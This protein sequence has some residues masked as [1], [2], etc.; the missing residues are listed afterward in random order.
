MTSILDQFEVAAESTFKM[1][2]TSKQLL[3]ENIN[4]DEDYRGV[5]ILTKKKVNFSPNEKITQLLVSNE[6]VVLVMVN[7]VLLRINLKQDSFEEIDLLKTSSLKVKQLFLDPFGEHLLILCGNVNSSQLFYTT[8]QL[9]KLKPVG[10]YQGSEITCVAWNYYKTKTTTNT[11]GPILL[12]NS[13]G[14]IIETELGTEFDRFFQGSVVQYWKEVFDI[15]KGQPTPII[16][17]EYHR[18]GKSNL[19]YILALTLTKLYQFV[20][21]VFNKDERPMFQQVFNNYLTIPER[22]YE[23]PTVVKNTKLHFYFSNNDFTVP[24]YFGFLTEVGVLFAE[25]NINKD[26]KT[27]FDSHKLIKYSQL[28]GREDDDFTVPLSMTF[29]RY[30][31]LL[32]FT[33]R[34]IAVSLVTPADLYASQVMDED[35]FSDGHGRFLNITKDLITGTV[36]LYAERAVFRYK[37]TKE[38]RNVWKVYLDKGMFEEAKEICIDNPYRMNQVLVRQA[39]NFFNTKQYEKSA[40]IYADLNVSFEEIVLKFLHLNEKKPLKLFLMKKLESLPLED[41]TKRIMITLW[42]IELYANE[43]TEFRNYKQECSPEYKALQESF[44]HFL[45]QPSIQDCIRKNWESIYDI[46]A[47]HGDAYFMIW[48]ALENQDFKR[49]IQHYLNEENIA[50]AL[51]ILDNH[52]FSELFYIFSSDLIEKAPTQTVSIL[53]KQGQKLDPL[54]VINSLIIPNPSERLALEIIRY[55]EYSIHCLN[56]H[57][58]SV[59]NYLISLYVKHNRDKLMNY[60]KLQGSEI[61][62]VSYNPKFALRLCREYQ[63]SK[64]C[65]QLSIVLGLWETAVDLAL[66][67]S[68]DLAKTTASLP[69]YDMELSKKLWL[70]IAQ[71]VVKQNNDIEQVMHFLEECKFIKIEDILPFFPDFVTIDHFKDA[72]CSSLEEYNKEI[73]N[74]KE[75]MEDATNSAEV[76][77]SEILSFRSG[78]MLIQPSNICSSCQEQLA[79]KAFYT[80]PCT[81]CFHAECLVKEMQPYIDSS[82]M[83]TIKDLQNQLNDLYQNNKGIAQPSEL[84]VQRDKVKKALDKLLAAECIFCSDIMIGLIDKPFIEDSDFERIKQEWE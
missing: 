66:T 34:V 24:K 64:A 65:V 1:P 10:K 74:L 57:V 49:V 81:H 35:Y 18:V 52:P 25:I 79:T 11:T 20:D 13:S 37:I 47:S 32:L 45:V 23:V 72:V 27:I 22:F 14:E 15:S 7:N 42:S 60:L 58:E 19:F 50:E 78:Y 56:C 29:T 51:N 63:L 28:Y 53:I 54:K 36:W 61:S 3:G 21:V 41:C 82:T 77:R 40:L 59:H 9:S 5:S 67:I 44:K 39:D 71:H 17:L 55:L 38:D 26:E 48:L 31:V 75:E 84:I 80:F 62:A 4:G 68:V 16:G 70:K 46:L 73:N 6:Y 2:S 33:E 83:N 30:H 8:K 76:I 12:G 43:L 69:N